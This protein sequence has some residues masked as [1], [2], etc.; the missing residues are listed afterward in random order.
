MLKTNFCLQFYEQVIPARSQSTN[1]LSPLFWPHSLQCGACGAWELSPSATLPCFLAHNLALLCLT[2]STHNADR[3]DTVLAKLSVREALQQPDFTVRAMW[4]QSQT[5]AQGGEGGRKERRR[6]R[7]GRVRF[8]WT[9]TLLHLTL[10]LTS[11]LTWEV[12]VSLG[13]R[14]SFPDVAPNFSQVPSPWV[15]PALSS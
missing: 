6:E 13:P 8:F 2:V 15:S 1:L 10:S 14:A 7:R 12:F 9:Q 4:V 3:G 11:L 5:Q